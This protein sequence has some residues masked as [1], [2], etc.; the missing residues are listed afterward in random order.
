MTLAVPRA[1]QQPPGGIQPDPTPIG[2]VQKNT[3]MCPSFVGARVARVTRLNQCG[4]PMYGKDNMATTIGMVTV[5][6]EPEVEEGEALDTRNLNGDLCVAASTPDSMTGINVSIE[7]CQVDPSVFTILNPTWKVVRRSWNPSNQ[8]AEIVGWRQ[9]Q[10]FSDECGFALELWPKAMGTV[11]SACETDPNPDPLDP[12]QT[13]GYFLLPYVVGKAP[14]EWELTGDEVATF[15]LQGRTRGGSPWGFGPYIVTRDEAGM[16][17]P[18]LNQIE[19]G[20]GRGNFPNVCY[21]WSPE[22][23]QPYRIN[24]DP[25]HF[26][27]EITSYPPPEPKCGAQPLLAP[28]IEFVEQPGPGTPDPQTVCIKLKNVEEIA[29]KDPATGK[30]PAV[31]VSWGDGSNRE[32]ITHHD[33][34]GKFQLCHTYDD[35]FAGMNMI[36]LVT[37]TGVY[38]EVI[39]APGSTI[40]LKTEPP[41][42]WAMNPRQ[43]RQIKA[44]MQVAGRPTDASSEVTRLANW[45]SDRPEVVSVNNLANKGMVYAHKPGFATITAEFGGKKVSQR[46]T[47]IP[48]K[49][50]RL[51]IVSE[52]GNV[53]GDN[54]VALPL[55][56]QVIRED[57]TAQ[58]VRDVT[59]GLKDLSSKMQA[60]ISDKGELTVTNVGDLQTGHGTVTASYVESGK[61]FTAEFR[62]EAVRVHAEDLQ[63][64]VPGETHLMYMGDELQV[65]AW[66]RYS[67]NSYKLVNSHVNTT[68]AFTSQENPNSTAADAVEIT[69]G[70]L[71]AAHA[72]SGYVQ[73]KYAPTADT[74]VVLREPWFMQVIAKSKPESVEIVS[75]SG[76]SQVTVSGEPLP[77]VARVKRQGESGYEEITLKPGAD[78]TFTA[79]DGSTAVAAVKKNREDK[80]A[81]LYAYKASDDGTIGHGTVVIEYTEGTYP[82]VKSDPF[83]VSIVPGVPVDELHILDY[84]QKPPSNNGH[85]EVGGDIFLTPVA[86]FKGHTRLVDITEYPNP[87]LAWT[88]V[89]DDGSSAAVEPSISH[90]KVRGKT[91]GFGTVKAT[92]TRDGQEQRVGE[93]HLEIKGSSTPSRSGIEPVEDAPHRVTF[94]LPSAPGGDLTINWGDGTPPETVHGAGPHQHTYP[95]A[96]DYLATVRDEDG[97]DVA[98][99]VFTTTDPPKQ[100][101]SRK[102]R[103]A[104]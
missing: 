31:L 28:Q 75:P 39:G 57:T 48:T 18:L 43:Q 11:G 20:S 82:A 63:L 6:F 104:T 50:K 87:P 46:V 81:D 97:N 66:V 42:Q 23:D 71:K 14:D 27:A 54:G 24:R 16:P 38:G 88:F 52:R 62:F 85:V 25:D 79:N 64:E 49:A 40:V 69:E 1:P 58:Y 55:F 26:H 59:W 84:D 73:V 86:R 95:H 100:T 96:G 29:P 33:L 99:Q 10:S 103:K 3:P 76:A 101:R 37:L 4:A 21:G 7:F 80:T 102:G 93:F 8:N 78:W 92:L 94:T 70:L 19:D 30:R 17:S 77:L 90:G 74:E 53:I 60:Q 56:A 2:P 35:A 45:T 83:A 67:D 5:T 9:G 13:N 36:R 91:A 41:N 32:N 12:W 47:V 22:L 89:P 65:N 61:T 15:T 44:Y 72:G 34:E 51:E 68:W 98:Q